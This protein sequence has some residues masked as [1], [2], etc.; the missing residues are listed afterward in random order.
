MSNN[1]VVNSQN[2]LE[3]EI[4]IS[5]DTLQNYKKLTE[6]IPELQDWV[7]TGIITKTMDLA[8]N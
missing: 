2:D 6:M 8:I 4:G 1:S 5:V 7:Q 3:K